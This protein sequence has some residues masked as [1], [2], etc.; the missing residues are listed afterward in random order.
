MTIKHR[1]YRAISRQEIATFACYEGR[2]IRKVSQMTYALKNIVAALALAIGVSFSLPAAAIAADKVAYFA[3]GCFW[4][5]E[6]DFEKI[7]GV[8]M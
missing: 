4:C 1:N 6:A 3:G 7:E 5:T 8:V 2:R